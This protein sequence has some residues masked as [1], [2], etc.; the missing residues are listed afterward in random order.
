MLTAIRNSFLAFFVLFSSMTVSGMAE[1]TAVS[2]VHSAVERG[3][4][5]LQK[6]S[7]RWKAAKGCAACHH[8]ALVVWTFNEAQARGY[9]VDEPAFREITAWT[10][11]NTK[12]NIAAEQAPPRDVINL[13]AVYGL[14]SAEITPA[15]RQVLAASQEQPA[16]PENSESPPGVASPETRQTLL[17]YIIKEQ[18]A[19]GSWGLPMD[20]R[21]PLG[22]PVEDIAILSRIALLQS[23]DDSTTVTACLDKAA[24]W[25]AAHQDSTSRQ[26]R[27]LRLMMRLLEGAPSE[28]IDPIVAAIKAEQNA[29]GG[30]SQTPEM[31][32]D[33]YATG[34]TLYVLSRA[35]IKPEDEGMAKGVEFLTR[36]QLKDG[37][38]PMISR[39]D[40]KDT[41]PIISAGSAWA[42]LGILRAS[43]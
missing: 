35:G 43:P 9:S 18:E 19:D 5:F 13:V 29:D 8:A 31:A 4:Q 6:D 26:G 1:P 23:G 10:F 21:V 12:T 39:V 38:W 36:T 7:Y 30:W 16:P 24:A 2:P 22:G 27:N 3:M 17:E 41:T 20:E 34:Q 25:L 33:A 28:E 14:L 42:V 15:P 40:S 37:S 32:S 11:E